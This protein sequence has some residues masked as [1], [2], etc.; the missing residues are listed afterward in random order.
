MTNVKPILI[1]GA[2]ASGKSA[3]ALVL[4]EKF[5]GE[6]INADSMQVYAELDILTAR[7]AKADMARAPHALYGHVPAREAY[8]VGRF[9]VDAASAIS[10]AVRAGRRPI[11]VGGTGLY[12]KALTEGLSP[13]PPVDESIRAH[14]RNE[15]ERH[16][17]A[18]LHSRLMQ[19]DPEM[20][21]RLVANDTQRIVRALEVLDSSG[22]SLAAWQRRP[23][24]PVVAEDTCVKRLVTRPREELYARAGARF[25]AMMEAGAYEEAQALAAL[26]LD[27]ALPAMRALGVA[28]LIAA[29]RGE[30]PLTEAVALAKTETRQFIKRQETWFRRY[31]ISWNDEVSQ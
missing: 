22:V 30:T 31:M 10:G 7:P 24:T 9:V 13:I 11:L 6:I 16:G 8:S 21:A 14:W 23:G 5:G 28:P 29:A 19:R 3:L 25:D 1:A 4:A 18:A 17:G 27:S 15:A 12:F 20:A 2:T 26:G